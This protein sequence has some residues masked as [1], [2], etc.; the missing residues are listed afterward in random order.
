M[1][2]YDYIREQNPDVSEEELEGM[3]SKFC[4]DS[5]MKCDRFFR[6]KFLL[7]LSSE[8]QESKHR[9]QEVLKQAVRPEIEHILRPIDTDDLAV[10]WMVAD[11][12]VRE[13]INHNITFRLQ[14]FVSVTGYLMIK[15]GKFTQEGI[16]RVLRAVEK[17][18]L[19]Q[20][21]VERQLHENFKAYE[22][23]PY[24]RIWNDGFELKDTL[25]IDNV[26]FDKYSRKDM[27]LRKAIIHK[28]FNLE[29]YDRYDT[30]PLY[31][32]SRYTGRIF[33]AITKGEEDEAI[34][35]LF[36][37]SG[38]GKGYC[39]FMVSGMERDADG[40][41]QFASYIFRDWEG[42]RKTY[43]RI[44]NLEFY[45]QVVTEQNDSLVPDSYYIQ[46]KNEK[47]NPLAESTVEEFK[48]FL[49]RREESL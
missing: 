36:Q 4:N 30:D 7:A 49:L 34:E 40:N 45:P 10:L 5:R 43:K 25:F 12:N 22:S 41:P 11:P 39:A 23:E 9:L 1:F 35:L 47:L 29:D 31:Y 17:N 19:P 26:L 16:H 14:D 28:P 33:E 13:I 21:E 8:N 38:R 6:Y 24:M 18:I 32:Q 27:S 20:E 37:Y 3:V 42:G 48:A 2:L 44:N 15:T 46:K